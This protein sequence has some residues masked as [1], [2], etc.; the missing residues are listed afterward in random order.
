MIRG[1][2]NIYN[3]P[4]V[5]AQKPSRDQEVFVSLRKF[6]MGAVAVSSLLMST[7]MS[8]S[9]YEVGCDSMFQIPDSMLSSS[10]QTGDN[11]LSFVL[12]DGKK[13]L[14]PKVVKVAKGNAAGT[15]LNFKGGIP[16]GS[17][18]LVRGDGKDVQPADI[19]AWDFQVCAPRVTAV[20]AD[21]IQPLANA[22]LSGKFFG[23]R[24]RAYL[25]YD[26]GGKRKYKPCKIA[27][28]D[29][30]DDPFGTGGDKYPMNLATG[31]SKLSITLPD[32]PSG[33]ANLA[34]EMRNANGSCGRFLGTN[35][36]PGDLVGWEQRGTI[37][38]K[39]FYFP[40]TIFYT[41]YLYRS[42]AC[43]KDIFDGLST[44]VSKLGGWVLVTDSKLPSD[45]F[46]S[47]KYDVELYA[48]KYM[49][50]YGS[51]KGA[52]QVMASG[53]IALPKGNQG[54]TVIFHSFQHGTMLEKSQAPSC[55]MGPELGVGLIFSVT[56]GHVM[57]FPDHIGLG[58]AA[59]DEGMEN[60][61]H[62]YCVA[63]P[64][65]VGDAYMIP[66]ARTFLTNKDPKYAA[67]V[68][69]STPLLGGYSEGGYITLALC[70]ELEANG[71]AYGV[72][73]VAA[74]CPMA[75]PHSLSYVMLNRLLS[76]TQTYPVQYFAPYLLVTYNSMYNIFDSA[77]K[78]FASPYD[79]TVVPLINGYHSSSEVEAAMPESEIPV[80]ALLKSF[81][82][83]LRSQT[84]DFFNAVKENDLIGGSQT[85]CPKAKT[86]L[87]HGQNDDCV[88]YENSS[89]ADAYFND[90]KM[91][92]ADHRLLKLLD[93]AW[94]DLFSSFT[95][96][97]GLYF[98]YAAGE[99]WSWVQNNYQFPSQ[100]SSPEDIPEV[101]PQNTPEK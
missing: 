21:S 49:A 83:S 62:P 68:S 12:L 5:V 9:D 99:Y 42:F 72:S 54:K 75:G 84:G 85:W 19:L 82:D 92:V 81:A 46:K 32:Y 60:V 44:V 66:A 101:V 40:P 55:S 28:P 63:S 77:S 25:S 17:Y 33:A 73:S 79:K 89:D 59:L 88:M 3:K 50:A 24:P 52:Q 100:S 48:L 26:L 29:Y 70:R 23:K 80:E 43:G 13:K 61:F 15:Y 97:H 20:V 10:V 16:A 14:N 39:W 47:G 30:Y 64:D 56:G 67:K 6:V 18:C 2:L 58:A 93:N 53:I 36:S 90:R 37:S 98:P 41:G 78:Y 96:K 1:L 7:M 91:P 94:I 76:T 27:N 22:T 65:A 87:I 35:F 8:A 4:G 95:I 11:E 57:I 31:D 38:H 69:F 86:Y 34:V 45:P 51:G 74:S 71:A